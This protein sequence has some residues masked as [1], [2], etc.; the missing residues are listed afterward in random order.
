MRLKGLNIGFALTGSFCTINNVVKEIEALQDEGANVI[1]IVSAAVAALDTR[2]TKADELKLLLKQKTGNDVLET[3]TDTEP[4]GPKAILDV[5]V[6]LPCTGNT[7]AKLANSITDTSVT[8]A[9]KA[10]LRN[11]RPVILGISTN[12]GLGGNAKNIGSLLN[13]KNIY[14]IPF[15]QDD[16]INKSKS[17]MAKQSLTVDTVIA[18]LEGKQLQPL[19]CK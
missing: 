12:D 11:E 3:I 15:Y 7:I 17:L 13:M 14:F 4:I 2:F 16:P 5:I 10:H 18:A 1:P 8:M 19:L 6:V 9:V